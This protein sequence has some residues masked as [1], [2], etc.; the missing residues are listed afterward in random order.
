MKRLLIL[1]AALVLAF[2]VL[3]VV[4]IFPLSFSTG[5][6]LGFPIHAPGLRWYAALFGNEFWRLGL[7]NSLIVAACATLAAT[8][9]ATPAALALWRAQFRGRGVVLAL[10][11]APMVVPAIITATALTLVYARAGLTGTLAGLVIAHTALISPFVVVTVLAALSRL[12]P[13]L[14]RAAAAS[15]GAPSAVFA[16]ITLPLVAPAIA[17]G[18]AFA[19]AVSLDESVVA[20]F[21][22]GPAQRTLPRQM[23]EAMRE[24]PDPTILAAASLLA[25]L[26][27]LLMAA[28]PLLRRDV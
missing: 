2:L 11:L 17:A 6:F 24:A 25:L 10:L 9:L 19:A 1:F 7:E 12:D 22:A 14:A 27:V 3:P 5:P 4:V 15:G 13:L 8:V 28:F 18:A 20:L 21:L 16:R 26:S 23:F